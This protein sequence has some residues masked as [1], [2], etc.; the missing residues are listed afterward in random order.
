MES[1]NFTYSQLL[2]LAESSAR[3]SISR[4]RKTY[5]AVIASATRREKSQRELK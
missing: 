2:A 1:V 4:D 5:S 3:K